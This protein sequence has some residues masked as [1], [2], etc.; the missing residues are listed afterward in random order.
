ML[1]LSVGS[2]PIILKPNLGQPI[3]LN[4]KDFKDRLEEYH[5]PVMFNT[6][7]LANQSHSLK[8]ILEYFHLNIYI[9]P[10]LKEEGEFQQRRGELFPIS[11]IE[12]SKIEKLDFKDQTILEDKNC[13]IWDLYNS[14]L[15]LENVFGKRTELYEINFKIELPIV[16]KIE[17]L[18]SELGRNFLLFDLVHDIPN[19]TDN[20]INFH[21]IAIYNKDW[22]NFEF[23]HASD[24][25]VARRNDFILNFIKEKVKAQMKYYEQK[26]KKLK[27]IDDF[28]LTRDFEYKENFQI[29]KYEELRYA[30]YNFNYNLRLFIDFVNERAKQNKLD[31]ILMTGDLIDYLNI[32][33][34]NYQYEN[35]F[36]V[37][38]D[39]LLGLNRGLEKPPQ[40][41]KD[42]EFINKKEIIVP[43]F[44]T[45]GN[46]DYRKEHYG[47][48]FGQIHKIFGLTNHDIKG[49]YDTKFFNYF[50]A[51][52]SHVKY[53][54]DYF[55]Y[56]NPNLNYNLKIGENY[57]FIFL[58]TGEDS[59]ADL[60][61]LLTG[62]PSTKGIKDEQ[63][64]LLRAYIKLSHDRKIIIVMHTPPISPNLNSRKI[65]KYKK[66]FGIEKREIEWSD[67]HEDNLKKINNTGR[68][69]TVLNL[70]Y[71]TIMYNWATLL[72]IV[73]G[74]DKEIRRKVDLIL[75]GHTHTLKEYRLKEARKTERIN[76]GFWFFPIYIE[77]PCEVYTSIYREQFK[78]YVSPSD[79]KIWFD[80]N[81]P[82]IFQVQAMGPI[83]NLYKYKPP[84]F[85]LYSIKND[86]IEQV[87]VF[88]LHLKGPSVS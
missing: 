58:D 49:Y 47:L 57:N 62:G 87:K 70:K 86:Q 15:Q 27:K 42:S 80:V 8:R 53:I 9:Q 23:I 84:G 48:R 20:K 75:C 39:I 37:L 7:I 34:G 83:S 79:L 5:K 64:D 41:G 13:I 22:D 66:K 61:D 31:F 26:E 4:L 3:L 74:S 28:V 68:L 85:R 43:I 14:A 55:R 30:K 16:K 21:S 18:L 59:I 56:F 46:H 72:R 19:R 71:E 50:T 29:A 40:L 44:T 12:I 82:F 10:I 54:K 76:F 63:V 51:L 81:K 38:I 25:H 33:K 1:D 60:H 45:I 17:K 67:F 11:L 35:N 24:F 32:A 52:K 88:S 77:V 36:Y 73:T 69:D 6:L 78:S 65:R 2:F